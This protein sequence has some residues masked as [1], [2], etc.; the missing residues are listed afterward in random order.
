MSDLK[1]QPSET[2]S[3]IAATVPFPILSREGVRACR[4]A[5]FSP[6][7]IHQ[8]ACS[9]MPGTLILRNA[10]EHSSFIND[11][12]THPATMQIV[13]DAAGVPLSIV[14]RTEIGHTN[15]QTA[16]SSLDEMIAELNVEPDDTIIPLTEEEQAYDTL[17]SRS[18]IPWQ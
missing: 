7:V 15:I 3:E 17:N 10:A 12:W 1:L 2:A 8:C 13:S 14:M 18:I 9:P 16:G 4:R 5:L 11:F 6:D